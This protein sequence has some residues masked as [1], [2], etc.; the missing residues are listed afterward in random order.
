MRTNY[1]ALENCV[2]RRVY[3]LHSRNLL[4]GVYDGKNGFIGVR[5]KF[6]SRYLF[7][8]YHYDTGGGTAWPLT[9]VCD[10][11]PE[12]ALLEGSSC[13]SVTGRPTAFDRPIKNGGRG[14]YF[15]DTGEASEAI[16]SE[17]RQNEPLFDFLEGLGE[18]A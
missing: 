17:F 9:E 7:T 14:W 15:L 16:R 3:R 10:V 13:D 11:P 5:Q 2:P 4:L 8:E 6:G 1:I 12:I 18:D